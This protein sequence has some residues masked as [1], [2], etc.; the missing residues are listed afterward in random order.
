MKKII[1]SRGEEHELMLII[2]T[3]C[4]L[5]TLKKIKKLEQYKKELEGTYKPF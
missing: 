3:I 2:V 1:D 4:S 5:I